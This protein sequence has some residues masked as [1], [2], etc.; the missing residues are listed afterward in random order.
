MNYHSDRNP[1]P[2]PPRDIFQRLLA[3]AS[4]VQQQQASA[5]RLEPQ[6]NS[7]PEASPSVVTQSGVKQS[8]DSGDTF[9]PAFSM[10]PQNQYTFY[11]RCR[12]VLLDMGKLPGIRHVILLANML[13]RRAPAPVPPPRTLAPLR[14]RPSFAAPPVAPAPPQP[15]TMAQS[16][17]PPPTPAPS[18]TILSPNAVGAQPRLNQAQRT[19]TYAPRTQAQAPHTA[20]QTQA[21]VDQARLTRDPAAQLP[22][23]Q[24]RPAEN[25]EWPCSW[26][27]F[28]PL[29]VLAAF[30]QRSRDF[31]AKQSTRWQ[32]LNPRS[33][34]SRR[35]AQARNLLDP[36][37]RRN[38]T[39]A[40]FASTFASTFAQSAKSFVSRRRKL[41][42]ASP[43][44]SSASAP[45][46]QPRRPILVQSIRPREFT[47]ASAISA[48]AQRAQN[49]NRSNL[50]WT[51]KK[52]WNLKRPSLRHLFAPVALVAV[53]LAF[54]VQMVFHRHG[55]AQVTQSQKVESSAIPAVGPTTAKSLTPQPVASQPVAPQPALPKPEAGKLIPAAEMA[56][57]S[58]K[59]MAPAPT[60]VKTASSKTRME[61]E[62]RHFGNDVTVRT[63]STRPT[64]RPRQQAHSRTTNIGDD[65]T[66][67]YYA[68]TKAAAR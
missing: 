25:F 56:S 54:T 31:T 12:F 66:V 42:P 10:L 39:L 3:H 55:P 48:S 15:I 62:V 47:P 35:A 16:P 2:N 44:A 29:A 14:T 6:A 45:R 43:A 23:L 1:D 26:P 30:L 61:S 53:V 64:A 4:A 60:V 36:I 67:R 24:N 5:A 34:V 20:S 41:A 59:P 46:T 27:H 49:I 7:T 18:Q 38:G 52:N 63:F 11:A 32:K 58:P 8:A 37:F 33:A 13:P 57:V 21:A 51:L 40:S 65:V 28:V 50:N 9:V 68:P 22:P 19:Q 17:T